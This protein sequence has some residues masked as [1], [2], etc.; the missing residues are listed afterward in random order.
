MPRDCSPHV[1][2]QFFVIPGL[3]DEIRRSRLHR[4]DCVFDRAVSRN[5]DYRK[6]RGMSVNLG[7]KV[8]AVAVGQ[9]QIE[10]HQIEAAVAQASQ[11]IFTAAGRVHCVAL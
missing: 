9:R 3:L 5:H 1:G 6:L 11:S 7:E 4:L 8:N 10:Q 2:Q